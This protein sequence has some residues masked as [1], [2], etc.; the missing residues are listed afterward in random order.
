MQ[1]GCHSVH[2]APHKQS[3]RAGACIARGNAAYLAKDGVGKPCEVADLK[4]KRCGRREHIRHIA[5]GGD[6]LLLGNEQKAA[7][8]C[9]HI[10]SNQ[11]GKGGG[12]TAA[13][14]ARDQSDHLPSSSLRRA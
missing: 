1:M 4:A 6:G 11:L 12:L 14:V 8:P 2:G 10:G 7:L 5:L 13:E 9:C 3:T